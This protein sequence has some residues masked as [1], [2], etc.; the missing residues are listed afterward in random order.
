MSVTLSHITKT[1]L[2]SFLSSSVHLTKTFIDVHLVT[3]FYNVFL[4]SLTHVRSSVYI[5]I[6]I[7]I[8]IIYFS[9]SYISYVSNDN[10]FIIYVRIPEIFTILHRK[11]IR[12]K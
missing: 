10:N 6:Y 8:Y 1:M 5:Y 4:S 2:L 11:F 9:I 3:L 7:Y 12:F